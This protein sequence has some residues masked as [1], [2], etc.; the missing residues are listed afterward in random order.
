M[1]PYSRSLGSVGSIVVGVTLLFG[2]LCAGPLFAD[3]APPA[4]KEA[5]ASPAPMWPHRWVTAL[6]SGSDRVFAGVADGL[7]L[8]ESNVVSFAASDPTKSETLYSH[9]TSVWAVVA[10]ADGSRLASTDYKGNLIIYSL[11]DKQAALKESVFERWTR[12]LTFTADGANLV[13]ANEGGKIFLYDVA[14]G[15]VAK[16]VETDKQQIY[17]VALSPDGSKIACGDG[18]G[19]LHLLKFPELESIKK[20]ACGTEPLWSVCFTANGKSVVAGGAD[21][22]LRSIAVE[23]EGEPTVIGTTSDWITSIVPDD[24]GEMAVGCMDGKM[25][26]TDGAT[27]EPVGKVPSGIWSIAFADGKLLAA[28]RKHMVATFVPSWKVGYTAPDPTK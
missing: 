11:A 9:P 22:S 17:S 26:I 5:D 19:N 13:A 28:T 27:M 14:K 21:R 2:V 18:A 20:V 10:T 24:K 6:T 8:R 1:T 12:A 16:S 15:E 7:L 3:D 4:G 23:G 25:F